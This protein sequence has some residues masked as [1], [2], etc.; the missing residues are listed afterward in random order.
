M[1]LTYG[2]EYGRNDD[3]D[4]GGNAG[5]YEPSDQKVSVGG[6]RRKTKNQSRGVKNPDVE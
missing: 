5:A 3:G 1:E 4:E 6:R 2:E